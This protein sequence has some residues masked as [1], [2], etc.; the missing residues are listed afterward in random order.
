MS[1]Q[2]EIIHNSRANVNHSFDWKNFFESS[3]SNISIARCFYVNDAPSCIDIYDSVF[4]LKLIPIDLHLSLF[5]LRTILQEN[6]GCQDA[7]SFQC[8]W[9]HPDFIS[10]F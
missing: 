1:L 9:Q 4:A 3:K 10:Y 5:F 6:E 7:Y 2:R 8:A